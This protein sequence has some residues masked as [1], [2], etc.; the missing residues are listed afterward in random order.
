MSNLETLSEVMDSE[1][2]IDDDEINLADD[3]DIETEDD[4]DY[5]AETDDEAGANAD[6][7]PVF[8]T[9][10]D[11]RLGDLSD[12]GVLDDKY[13][14]EA[15]HFMDVDGESAIAVDESANADESEDDE[16]DDD[17]DEKDDKYLQKFDSEVRNTFIEKYHPEVLSHNYEEVKNLAK[18]TRDKNGLVVDTLHKTLPFLTK[19]E[20]A[21]II[22]QRAKQIDMGAKPMFQVKQGLIDSYLIALKELELKKIPFII[23][24][25][26]P[27]GGFEYWNL[28]DLELLE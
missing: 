25:P 11:Y 13:W 7:E 14:E 16:D 12:E 15:R 3:D 26:I 4:A 19:Y 2:N 24:R 8:G 9:K 23:K 10:T 6:T 1:L 21:R 18:I 28:S 27:N 5:E 20:K 17:D 22:G